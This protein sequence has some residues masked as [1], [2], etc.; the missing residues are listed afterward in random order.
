MARIMTNRHILRYVIKINNLFAWKLLWV[1]LRLEFPIILSGRTFYISLLKVRI[2]L[3][4][5]H[6]RLRDAPQKNAALIWT[7]SIGGGGGGGVPKETK[8][9]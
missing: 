6:W 8:N 2:K 5:N 9:F 4:F 3:S 7:P 1:G